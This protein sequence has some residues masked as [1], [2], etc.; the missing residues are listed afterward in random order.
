MLVGLALVVGDWVTL[1]LCLIA[2]WVVRMD[3]LPLFVPGLPTLYSLD[4]YFRGLYFFAPWL[5]AI[6]A[7][8][9]YSR[10]THFWDEVRAVIRASTW[11]TIMAVF[12]SYT[13][14][15]EV[16]IARTLIFSLWLVSL[17]ALSLAR[18]GLKIALASAGLWRRPV[19]VIGTGE[20]ASSVAAGLSGDVALGYEPVAFVADSSVAATPVLGELPVVGPFSELPALLERFRVRDVVIA[21]PEA[22]REELSRVVSLCEGRLDSLRVMPDLIGMA[23]TDIETDTVGGNLL[24]S[25]RSSLAQPTNLIIKR[26]TDILGAGLLLL[27]MAPVL[28][29]LA[30]WVRLDSK[31]PAFYVQERVGRHGRLFPC[32]KFRTMY[33]DADERLTAHLASDA[34]AR[35]EWEHYKKLKAFDP[36]VTGAGRLLRRLSLDELPQLLNVLRGEMSLVGPRPYI[37]HELDGHEDIFRTILLAWPGITGLWQV[38]GRNELKLVQRFRLDEYYVRNWSLWLDLQ[39]LVRTFG[40]LARSDG[41]Y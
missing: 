10:H 29:L 13:E 28:A 38:S 39:I 9:L 33:L 32:F 11:G 18:Y 7:A 30:L 20:A 8:R 15:T 6:A 3:I 25:M 40:V 27:P 1:S 12:L 26:T 35:E 16:E 36:R 41:A 19:L 37:E 23:V 5:V 2:V 17:P 31:G 14:H 21:M 4:F 22:G 34:A 24:I